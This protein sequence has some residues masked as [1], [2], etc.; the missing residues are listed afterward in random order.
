M[1]DKRRRVVVTGFGALSPV[2]NTA[3]ESWDAVVAGRSGVATITRFDPA[4]YET[5]FAGE[6][7]GFDPDAI[8]GKKEARRM[9]RHAQLGV[10]A[11]LEA[12]ANSG[13]EDA[14][15]DPFRV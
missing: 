3:S 9:D 8:L 15:V 1:V 2:G 11:A 4:E 14:G 10:A 5:R 7:K 6:V 12:R 13:L